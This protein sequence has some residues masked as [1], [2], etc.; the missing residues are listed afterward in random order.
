[1]KKVE[2]HYWFG[3][4]A[5]IIVLIFMAS[6]LWM[7]D[8]PFGIGW[9]EAEYFDRALSDLNH[10]KDDGLVAF[11][12]GMLFEDTIRPPA[13][14]L[15]VIPFTFVFGFSPATVRL[16]S[17]SIFVFGLVFVYL[18]AKNIAGPS[19]GAFALI[20]LSLSPIMIFSSLL[21]GTEYPLFLATTAM[22][23]FL[24]RN[25]NRENDASYGW[26][27]L[28][29]SLG[30]GALAKTSFALVAGPVLA[31]SFL[32]SWRKI[33]A[34]P[35]PKFFLRAAGLG[36]IIA[37]PWWILNYRPAL[38]YAKYSS[39]FARHSLGPL[40]VS[41]F[42]KRLELYWQSAVGPMLSVLLIA[43]LLVFLFRRMGKHQTNISR[44]EGTVI[45]V[46][47][48]SSLPIIFAQLI[49]KND[50]LR[51]IAP[52]LILMAVGM[53]ILAK[54]TFW[55]QARIL[56]AAASFLFGVQ[57][58]MT[59]SPI[60]NPVI[61]PTDVE[62]FYRPPWLVMA[63]AEQWDWEPLREL[64]H[65]YSIQEPAISFL[66]AGSEFNWPAITYPWALNKEGLTEV[67]WLWR[68]EDGPINW[69]KVMDSIIDSDLVLTAPNYVGDP[70]DRQDLDNQYN[71]EF[72]LRLENDPRFFGPIHLTLGR[73][74]P[75]ELAVFVNKS[76]L[77]SH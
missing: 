8:H 39:S 41:T 68:Y 53:G 52:A 51:H 35:K 24:F 59:V 32:L 7:R 75:V 23:F 74:E 20:F 43:V 38:W 13:Y 54:A 1:M 21:F 60:L 72:A 2:Q 34:N 48:L 62:L 6:V 50:N 63:R 26:V 14:R 29:L 69:D 5:L 22:L 25:W 66:G 65:S 58:L 56:A 64:A 40:S 42:I 47:F 45:L 12:R 10:L 76:V 61:Y 3:F 44:T 11:V 28:G 18:T 36:L 31:V 9:D 17:L 57:L 70:A 15:L 49:G 19:A 67:K 16:V 46:C 33:I 30:L 27:G 55:T 71:Q 77:A 37:F 73:F 4:A